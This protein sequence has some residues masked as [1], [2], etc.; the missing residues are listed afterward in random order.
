M[1]EFVA[2][3][4]SLFAFIFGLVRNPH[5]AEDIFQEVWVRFSRALTDGAQ[6]EDQAKW[7]RGTARNLILHHW[8]D[9][10]K[11]PLP[12]DDELLDLAELAFAEQEN[13]PDYRRRRQEAL[14]ECIG[15]LP[16]RSQE[17]L[18]LKYE[19]WLAAE[20]IGEQLSQTAAAV[21]MSL[22]RIRKALR[23]CAARKL[24]GQGA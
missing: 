11:Q 18:R 22:S 8:R 14:T 9:Q 1:A 20:R 17:I 15:E 6:I 23:D 7:C 13:N 24:G 12:V 2:G 21:L 3:R 19:S 4:H 16:E 10:K 5:D